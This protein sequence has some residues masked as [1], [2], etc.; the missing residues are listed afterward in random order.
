MRTLS[1]A[2]P[3]VAG[4]LFLAGHDSFRVFAIM[5]IP[6]FYLNVYGRR[7]RLPGFYFKPKERYHRIVLRHGLRQCLGNLLVLD[8]ERLDHSRPGKRPILRWPSQHLH[9]FAD[10]LL[11]ALLPG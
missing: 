2:R 4:V 5:T 1:F 10:H 8:R 11:R 9:A 7:T 3:C 6:V